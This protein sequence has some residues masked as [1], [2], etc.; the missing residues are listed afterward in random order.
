MFECIFPSAVGL[1]AI[2]NEHRRMGS[3]CRPLLSLNAMTDGSTGWGVGNAI[4]GG[5]Q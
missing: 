5:K 1:N 2:A 4:V 3:N